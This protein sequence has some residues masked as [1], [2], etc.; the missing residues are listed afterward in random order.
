MADITDIEENLQNDDAR[1]TS[2]SYIESVVSDNSSVSNE[3]EPI[4]ES[5]AKAGMW[6][7]IASGIK[8]G[9]CNCN[10]WVGSHTAK[11]Y[12]LGSVER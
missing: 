9:A 1:D 5:N 10:Y 12:I 11:I 6:I 3:S 4:Q 7:A 2:E 8:Y